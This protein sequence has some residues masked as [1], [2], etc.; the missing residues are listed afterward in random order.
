MMRSFGK[1]D[2]LMPDLEGFLILR[3]NGDG[4]ALRLH[5]DPLGIVKNSQAQ[6]IASRL[7]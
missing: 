3:M 6:W 7:K 5:T 4:K 1:T 2:L